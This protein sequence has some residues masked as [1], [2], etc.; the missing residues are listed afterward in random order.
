[1]NSALGLGS[2]G[3]VGLFLLQLALPQTLPGQTEFKLGRFQEITLIR[4]MSLEAIMSNIPENVTFITIQ[5]HALFAG[6]T[7]SLK[8]PANV[9]SSLGPDPSLLLSLK[10]RESMFTWL[11]QT[12]A[13]N[14]TAMSI[15]LPYTSQDPVPGGCSLGSN[16]TIDPNLHLEYNMYEA[17]IS[18]APANVGYT[19]GAAPPPCEATSQAPRWRLQYNIHQYFLPEGDLSETVLFASLQKMAE[20]HQVEANGVKLFQLAA[21]DETSIRVTSIRGQG[22]IYNVIVKDPEMK[23]SASYTPV[24]MYGCS[25]TAKLDNCYTLRSSSTRI[26]FVLVGIYGLFICYFGHQYLKTGFFFFGF[27]I[28][29]FLSFVLIMRISSLGYNV[30]LSLTGAL[31]YVGGGLMVVIW[32]RFG[33][34]P[35]S[36]L[37]VGL[38]LG[39]LL[40]SLVNFTPVGN[41]KVFQDDSVFWVTFMG[42]ALLVPLLFFNCPRALNILACGIIGS[43]AVVL[44]IH[45]FVF[46]SLAYITIN[47]L[48]RV[49]NDDFK[50]AYSNVPFQMNDFILISVW[51]VLLVS[52]VIFQFVREKDVL[53]FPPHP[54]QTW[55]RDRERRK[56]NVLDPSH[57]VPPIKERVWN[58]LATFKQLFIKQQP[59]GE[60]TPLLL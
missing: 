51:M 21:R 28:L 57:H 43:Y 24:H 32:W 44:A 10:P 19:R 6:M 38:V 50:V 20:V 58:A 49:L 16:L 59:V 12:Q 46:T 42:L 9:S 11:L 31:G 47:I 14:V 5:V 17:T 36:M 29:A 35:L 55:R 41:I 56:T 15:I 40:S 3:W 2:V 4:N 48:K 26:F 8:I 39:F 34:V 37:L 27:I 22:V 30:V 33:L 13:Q 25:F 54:Y 23:T 45:T 60:Q 18:F 1:M 7:L 53:A 52:G